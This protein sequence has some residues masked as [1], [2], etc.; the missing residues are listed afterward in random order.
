VPLNV[1]SLV[2]LASLGALIWSAARARELFVLSVR[3]GELLVVR[4]KLPSSLFEALGDVVERAGVKS[5]SIRVAKTG[6]Y[7]RLTAAGVDEP[8]L[9]RLRNVVGTFTLK[10]LEEASW[11]R[12][13]NLGQRLGV[14]WLAW[15]LR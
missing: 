12:R 9:Q 8:V 5:A 11:P 13:K 4:G 3:R 10:R 14:A 2:V 15:R 7:A 6:G 1:I